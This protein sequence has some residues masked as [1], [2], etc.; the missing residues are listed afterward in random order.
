[1]EKHPLI[2]EILIT[3][4]QIQQRVKELAQQITKDYQG[5]ELVVVGLL[6]GSW[7]YM[8][9]LVREIEM[10]CSCDFMIA[11]SYGSGTVSSHHL[12]ITRDISIDVEGKDVLIVEDIID[13][14]HTL[15]AVQKLFESRNVNSVEVTTLITKPSRREI[16][17]NV[18]YIGFEVPDKFIVGY[19]LDFDEK[20]RGYS[21]IGVLKEEAYKN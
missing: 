16:D 11:S 17:I 20:F 13:T 19:G 10:D 9:D 7:V 5:K 18:K 2:A 21:H 6:K 15:D 14:G 12:K 8:A 1:M 3:K 4:D